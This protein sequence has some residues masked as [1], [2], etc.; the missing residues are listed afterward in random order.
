MWNPYVSRSLKVL[1]FLLLL[2]ICPVALAQDDGVVRVNTDLVVLNV[3]VTDKTGH[4]VPSLKV[5]DFKIFEDGQEINPN[6][7]TSFSQHESPYAAVVLL[8]SSG[9][10]EERFS[11]ARSAAIRFLD[12]L[13]DEDVAAVFRF[14]SKV[15]RVQEFYRGR[16]VAP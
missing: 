4:Y 1:P 7:I 11:L 8:D 3:T 16:D 9:S 5:K 13:R 2:F 12:G 14:D 15:E 10:M 6:L